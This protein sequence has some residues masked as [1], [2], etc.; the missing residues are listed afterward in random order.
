MS[1]AF[2]RFICRGLRGVYAGYTTSPLSGEARVYYT[3]L[4]QTLEASP[5]RIDAYEKF[6]A[7]V[8]SAVR[9]AYQGAGFGES[10]R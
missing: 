9:H 5:I 8:D 10:E 1:R 4:F 3:E 6:L 7:G 2:L